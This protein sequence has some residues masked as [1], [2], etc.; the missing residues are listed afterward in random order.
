V[1]PGTF[2]EFR[3]LLVM[4]LEE[5]WPELEPLCIAPLKGKALAAALKAIA[6]RGGQHGICAQHLLQNFD[7]LILFLKSSRFRNDPR[8]IANA[9]AGAP[10]I[11][12]WRSLRLGQTQPCQQR[13]GMRALK[14]YIRRKHY[15]L[16]AMLQQRDDELHFV[17]AKKRY[18]T[19]DPVIR[20]MFAQAIY[21][22]WN[23]ARRG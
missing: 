3:D 21:H 23:M 11:G 8:Q 17:N 6:I 5:H 15:R 13:I 2:P 10:S 1:R 12:F 9:L 18:R 22:V 4:T 16:F 19:K 7:T 20:D 14:G